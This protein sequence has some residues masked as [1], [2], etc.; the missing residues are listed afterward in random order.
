MLVNLF[1]GEFRFRWGKLKHEA[2]VGADH[3]NEPPWFGKLQFGRVNA[4]RCIYAAKDVRQQDVPWSRFE[5][6]TMPKRLTFI[7]RNLSV[8]QNKNR[9]RRDYLE[10]MGDHLI[11]GHAV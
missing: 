8:I 3:G 5:L 1:P 9:Q 10:R 7:N 4:A 6:V 11:T 2:N